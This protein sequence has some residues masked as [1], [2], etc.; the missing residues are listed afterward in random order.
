MRAIRSSGCLDDAAVPTEIRSAQSVSS[1]HSLPDPNV[2][3][4]VKTGKAHY[5]HMFSALPLKADITLRTRY[6]RFVPI[7]EVIRSSSRQG[8][9]LAVMSF[10]QPGL[11]QSFFV[12][13]KVFGPPKRAQ[14]V[15]ESGNT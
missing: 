12:S 4:G 8:D 6:V 9:H 15:F 3:F 10:G 7:A 1:R 14:H 2:G 5:E 13:Q 11:P